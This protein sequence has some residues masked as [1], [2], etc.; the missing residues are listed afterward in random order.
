MPR[1]CGDGLWLI[2][3]TKVCYRQR[4][5]QHDN[6]RLN[7]SRKSLAQLDPKQRE[8]TQAHFDELF[9]ASLIEFACFLFVINI[10]SDFVEIYSR[11]SDKNR[12]R[13]ILHAWE[14]IN[15]Q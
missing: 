4:C 15:S 10:S 2:F 8:A 3:H 9:G 1:K 5:L 12:I 14:N 7:V 13:L 11:L 6:T